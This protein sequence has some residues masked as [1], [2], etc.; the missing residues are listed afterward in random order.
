[1]TNR[2]ELAKRLRPL[3]RFTTTSLGHPHDKFLIQS[4]GKIVATNGR[5]F[6]K[7][8]FPVEMDAPMIVPRTIVSVLYAMEG[9]DIK[10]TAENNVLV[11]KTEVDTVRVKM[12]DGSSFIHTP[13]MTDA[14]KFSTCPLH[15]I[16]SRY[17]DV[18]DDVILGPDSIRYI[19]RAYLIDVNTYVGT[20][21][22]VTVKN[23]SLK[24]ASCMITSKKIELVGTWILFQNDQYDIGIRRMEKPDYY[25]AKEIR[26]R[27][28]NQTKFDVSVKGY[29]FWHAI[30][31]ASYVYPIVDMSI[32][33]GDALVITTKND[34]INFRRELKGTVHVDGKKKLSIRVDRIKDVYREWLT[35]DA[36]IKSA[37]A[38]GCEITIGKIV[39]IVP[40]ALEDLRGF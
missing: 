30:L 9:E 34:L 22:F 1:M 37:D 40:S 3:L 12:T 17:C 36:R 25:N 13:V 4:D 29:Q 14:A 23:V 24:R 38:S 7:T 32:H 2:D 35:G 11:M 21:G 10:M 31:A 33:N 16:P 18:D 8:D 19:N 39:S 26:D 27:I 28:H 5:E 15:M 20:E 6:I